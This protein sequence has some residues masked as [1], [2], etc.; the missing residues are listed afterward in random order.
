[1]HRLAILFFSLVFALPGAVLLYKHATCATHFSKVK[2]FCLIIALSDRA[3]CLADNAR[4]K[5][6]LTC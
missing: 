3:L 5:V 6:N 4:R 1:M 2:I